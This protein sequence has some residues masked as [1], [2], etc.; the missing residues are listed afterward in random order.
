MIKS[1]ILGGKGVPCL[2]SFNSCILN[3]CYPPFF[4]FLLAYWK[5]KMKLKDSFSFAFVLYVGDLAC[6]FYLMLEIKQEVL[7]E[8]SWFWN[9]LFCH[10]CYQF[11]VK[12][13]KKYPSPFWS[14]IVI[15]YIKLL[16][17]VYMCCPDRSYIHIKK[18]VH[19]YCCPLYYF[20]K[21][22]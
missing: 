21:K 10:I 11:G 1:S 22:I 9:G 20:I 17:V 8:K 4:A 14:W 18:K 15:P 16:T 13:K 5:Y 3:V 6:N 2:L 19:S 12:G 7:W